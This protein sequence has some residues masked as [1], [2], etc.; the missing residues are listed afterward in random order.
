MFLSLTPAA[1]VTPKMMSL[2]CRGLILWFVFGLAGA[3]PTSIETSL[4]EERAARAPQLGLRPDGAFPVA[5]ASSFGVLQVIQLPDD[6]HLVRALLHQGPGRGETQQS[7]MPGRRNSG[8]QSLTRLSVLLHK[9]HM[10]DQW[11]RRTAKQLYFVSISASS[12]AFC[13]CPH[14]C[15]DG[16]DEDRHSPSEQLPMAV[17]DVEAAHLYGVCEGSVDMLCL[18]F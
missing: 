13:V 18:C 8:F 12:L 5:N 11:R 2:N 17:S 6:S 3:S 16:L 1:R 4:G 15:R 9:S 10:G 14:V 7:T